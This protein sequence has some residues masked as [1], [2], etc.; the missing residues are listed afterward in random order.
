MSSLKFS[1]RMVLEKAFGMGSGYVLNFS[2]R[3]FQEFIWEHV[4]RDICGGAYSQNGTSK[5]KHLRAFWEVESDE[6]VAVLIDAM[7]DHGVSLGAISEDLR[8]AGSKIVER[9]RG[10][11]VVDLDALRPNAVYLTRRLLV[12]HDCLRG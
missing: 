6:V 3:T 2:D 5:A 8:L 4:G 1:D 9:L 7:I 10:G 12:R 11:G